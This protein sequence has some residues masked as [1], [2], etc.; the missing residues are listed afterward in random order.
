MGKC[1]EYI[2]GLMLITC[3]FIIAAVFYLGYFVTDKIDNNSNIEKF[4][5]GFKDQIIEDFK[6][7]EDEDWDFIADIIF[8]SLFD[9]DDIDEDSEICLGSIKRL[10]FL[11]E[12][13]KKER[14]SILL[15]FPGLIFS[16]I[17]NN[18]NLMKKLNL[19]EGFIISIFI[20][21]VGISLFFINICECLKKFLRVSYFV[22]KIILVLNLIATF[23][24]KIVLQIKLW[25]AYDGSKILLVVKFINKCNSK[26]IFQKY[27][28]FLF[29][30]KKW[31][32]FSI[33]SDIFSIIIQLSISLLNYASEIVKDNNA[34]HQGNN[35]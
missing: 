20:L 2:V 15:L 19:I 16:K 17:N 33:F 10:E 5:E 3:A 8:D 27:F 14:N 4:Q 11:T 24:V 13:I 23:I 7:E 21:F 22:L 26:K 28:N 9:I 12:D 32:I 18:A 29:I 35:Y 1:N 25:I 34:D 30:I 6:E 31:N